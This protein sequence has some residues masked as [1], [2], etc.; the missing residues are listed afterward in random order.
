RAVQYGSADDSDFDGQPDG[1]NDNTA[2]K[3]VALATNNATLSDNATVVSFDD[4]VVLSGYLIAGPPGPPDPAD[5][6]LAGLSGV[7]GFSGGSVSGTARYNEVGVIE[8]AAAFS[9]AYLGRSIDLV[10][11]S[12]P[13]GRFHPEHFS[14]EGQM[15]GV[16]AAQC[17]GFT[18]T[19]QS[20]GYATAPEFT[21]A[22]RAYNGGG[23][24]LG[25]ITR[26]YRDDW[27]KLALA[28]ISRN[29]PT[30]DSIQTGLDGSLLAVATSPGTAT[31][32]PLGNGSLVYRPGADTFVYTRNNNARIAPFDAALEVDVTSVQ[33]SDSV[34]L[35]AADL[36]V[37]LPATGTSIRHGR[38]ALENAYGPETMALQI[39][40][41][42]QIWNGSR[43]TRHTD[44]NCWA[45][46]T[47]DAG[48]TNT[49]PNTSVDARSGTLT[50]GIAASGGEL[51]LTMPGNGNTG[52]VRVEYPVP[53]YWQDDFDGDGTIEDPSAIATFGV[54]RGHDRVIYWQ[55]R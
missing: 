17:N 13:V 32:T 3:T 55:E 31:L 20:F 54:Y 41:E 11:D 48:V 29:D 12:G 21:I 51:V 26:N 18:Y 22:A 24:G 15:D 19:G 9:S 14:L 6:G 36:P 16:L 38:L 44:E 50:N 33:D 42:A 35:S 10:G 27:Q 4:S 2:D 40:F 28:D 23:P 43:F 45:Y 8:V 39:P 53:T 34:A 47:A 49:P 25:S 7:S 1:H 52:S 5:P 30:A 37:L 46:N